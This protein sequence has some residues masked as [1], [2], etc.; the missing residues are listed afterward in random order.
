MGKGLVRDTAT[1]A[2]VAKVNEILHSCDAILSEH[3]G[4][5][6][7]GLY[8]QGAWANALTHDLLNV[9]ARLDRVGA[10]I[11]GSGEELPPQ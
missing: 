4:R 3:G 10:L 11:V 9:R 8:G 2:V 7:Q 6:E 5:A 1:M